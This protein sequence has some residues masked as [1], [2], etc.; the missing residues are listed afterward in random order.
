MLEAYAAG[1]HTNLY[2]GIFLTFFLYDAKLRTD[3]GVGL[4]LRLIQQPSNI[5]N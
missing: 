1:N 4:E 3:D 5:T 2:R